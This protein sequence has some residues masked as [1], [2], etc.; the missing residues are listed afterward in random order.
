MI[1]GDLNHSISLKQNINKKDYEQIQILENL[2]KINDEVNLKLELKYKLLQKKKDGELLEEVNEYFYYVDNN[3]VGY[4]GISS[5]GE[6]VAELNGMV[7][8]YWRGRKIF[9]KL[10]VLAMVECSRRNFK[11]ILLLSD[12]KSSSGNSFIK[13]NGAKYSFSEYNMKLTEKP[14][15]NTCTSINLR[16]ALNSDAKEISRQNHIYFGLEDTKLPEP[17][18]DEKNNRTTYM[19]EVEEKIVGKIRVSI[20]KDLAYISAFGVLPEYRRR[21][22][23]REAMIKTI[24][25]ILASGIDNISLD[26][27]CGNSNALNL[28]KSCGFSEQSK[29]NYYEGKID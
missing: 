8:P 3:L 29:M 12:D 18:E 20:E 13:S 2:C 28:Y 27:V 10:F 1:K 21:G 26:V 15:E 16:K 11:S 6:G 23:G 4:L 7:H 24:N 17:E 25:M 19:I 5:F 22:Y 9:K 14:L